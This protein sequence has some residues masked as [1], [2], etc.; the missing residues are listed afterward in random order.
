METKTTTRG[1][2]PKGKGLKEGEINQNE[3]EMNN[4]DDEEEEYKD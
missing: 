2:L 1:T 4:N 3:K